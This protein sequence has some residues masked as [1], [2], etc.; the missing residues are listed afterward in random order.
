[1]KLCQRMHYWLTSILLAEAHL[2][3]SQWWLRLMAESLWSF[4][5]HCWRCWIDWVPER[6]A[7]LQRRQFRLGSRWTKH[8]GSPS[9]QPLLAECHPLALN[10]MQSSGLIQF[11][12]LLDPA[13][14]PDLWKASLFPLL[15]AAAQYTPASCC[16]H[17]A[18]S[19]GRNRQRHI[20]TS[21]HKWTIFENNIKYLFDYKLCAC[22]SK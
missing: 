19:G 14:G 15:A 12:G 16:K 17:S 20:N 11:P 10:G 3:I 6:S 18:F 13:G 22:C 9:T 2:S 5:S 1:M 4:C 21:I 7:H 8:S